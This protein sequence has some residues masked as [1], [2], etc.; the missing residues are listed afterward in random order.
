MDSS[1]TSALRYTVFPSDLG[2]F[3]LAGSGSH[4]VRLSFGHPTADAARRSLAPPMRNAPR[5]DFW[6]GELVER[7]QAYAGGARDD[8]RDVLIAYEDDT[9]FR[10]S[11]A[12]WCRRI[13]P[14]VTVTY[15]QLAAAAGRPAAAWAVGNVMRTNRVPL[16]IPCHHVVAGTGKLHGYSAAG[17]LATKRRLLDMEIESWIS[18]AVRK[19]VEA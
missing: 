3:A 6:F 5:D 4:V 17:G 15:G 14:G 13:P 18:E 7:L 1:R 8:F 9:R 10:I 2:W 11:V 12:Q 19:V 16:I